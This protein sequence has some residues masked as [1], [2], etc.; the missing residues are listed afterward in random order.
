MYDD[1]NYDL[2]DEEDWLDEEN[3]DYSNLDRVI[4]SESSLDIL[5]E[6]ME[7]E[8]EEIEESSL[9]EQFPNAQVVEISDRFLTNQLSIKMEP[10]R[11]LL[12]FRMEGELY[13]G[14]VLHKFRNGLYLFG[15]EYP[16]RCMKR[17]DINNID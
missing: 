15:L 2:Y 13:K 6:T 10:D 12:V 14:R 3:I 1:I 17:I 9:K 8:Y 5:E 4:R 11:K 16:E 7:E